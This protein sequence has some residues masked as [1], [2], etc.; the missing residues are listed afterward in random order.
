MT[1]DDLRYRAVQTRDARFDGWFFV[2]V[3]T[4]GIYCRPSCASVLPG[5]DRVRFHPTAAACQRA[6]FRACKRCR[7]DASPGSPEWNWRGDAVGRAMREIA[8][9]VVDREGVSG[10]AARLGYSARQLN[11]LLLAEV[12]AGPLELAR[13][14]RAQTARIL[15]ETTSL[16]ASDVAFAAGFGS[17]R[18]F[19]DTIREVFAETPS[20]LRARAGRSSLRH[21]LP[22]GVGGIGTAH[23]VRGD[24]AAP[25][26]VT[27]R[28][29]FR[30]PFVWE[31]LFRF[32]ESHAIPGVEAADGERLARAL[33]LPHGPAVVEVR[34]PLAGERWLPA[35]VHLADLRDLTVAVRRVRQ[36]LDL[37]ADPAAVTEML[38]SDAL[39][40]PTV[41][42]LP[43]LRVPGHVDGDELAVHAVLGQQVS[44][45]AARTAGG[46]L[47]A[48]FGEDLPAELAAV[49]PG[50]LVRRTFPTAETLADAG[51]EGIARLITP[52]S[53]GAALHG[54][55][56]ALADGKI[57]IDPGVDRDEVSLALG[58][59]RGIGPWTVELVRMRALADPDAFLAGDLGVK[60]A[61]EE[62]GLPGDA[63]AAARAAEGWRPYRAYAQQYLWV[64]LTTTGQAKER[65]R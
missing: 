15:L 10:L 13:A 5:R 44:V 8:D 7:P 52:G 11:R 27:L 24:V 9:G 6:G 42:L 2:C 50:G 1:D 54:L 53:K 22:A 43:G 56:T 46:K 37:D 51:P 31:V 49:I 38:G 30:E 65:R 41:R 36:M 33:S 64:G 63:R 57:R 20:Q 59:L 21:R 29:A 34:A 18:Q 47:V 39:L 35:T 3:T 62:A 32:F 4:T 61:L 19:N 28:L 60:R 16:R 25:S 17:I 45:A 55:V 23:G 40:G 14:Q 12:G 58:A 48:A 26:S